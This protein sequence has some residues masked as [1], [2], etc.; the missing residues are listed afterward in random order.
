MDLRMGHITTI[1]S[2]NRSL[3]MV[4]CFEYNVAVV[5]LR[6]VSYYVTLCVTYSI[7]AYSQSGPYQQSIV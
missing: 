7:G 3:A 4:G 1:L 2:L 5:H 6:S